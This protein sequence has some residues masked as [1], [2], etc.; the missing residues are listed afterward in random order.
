M[1][2][3]IEIVY[4]NFQV[5]SDCRINSHTLTFFGVNYASNLTQ[6]LGMVAARISLMV[7]QNLLA[8]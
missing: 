5:N 1:Y 7:F 4:T 2:P 3:I 6:N 8:F